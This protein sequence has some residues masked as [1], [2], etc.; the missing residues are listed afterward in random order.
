M[1]NFES[2]K[3]SNERTGYVARVG[4]SVAH[5]QPGDKVICLERGHYDT[6][7]RS[8]A[9]KCLKLADDAEPR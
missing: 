9:Q 3:S 1:G 7:L 2:V 6:F 5:L 4:R 8:P